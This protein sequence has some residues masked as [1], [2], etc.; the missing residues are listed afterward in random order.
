MPSIAIG[1]YT[2]KTTKRIKKA[3]RR[4]R[5]ESE[6]EAEAEAEAG[7]ETTICTM[8]HKFRV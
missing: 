1:T 4:Y 2:S 3:N 5:L 7:V 8:V 6:I